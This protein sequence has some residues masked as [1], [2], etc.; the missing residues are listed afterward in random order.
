[1]NKIDQN[2]R[3][4][5]L[6]S[7]FLIILSSSFCVGL[8]FVSQNRENKEVK[9]ES[10]NVEANDENNQQN[11]ENE[12]ETNDQTNIQKE[13]S[14]IN[15]TIEDTTENV[16]ET[17]E[18]NGIENNNKDEETTDSENTTEEENTNEESTDSTTEENGEPHVFQFID[19]VNCAEEFE[20]YNNFSTKYYDLDQTGCD[21]VAPEAGVVSFA[22]YV[23]QG[24]WSVKIDY[25]NGYQT[26]FFHLKEYT[27]EKDQQIEKGQKV[28]FMGNT[29]MTP[30]IRLTI[31]FKIDNN[32]S[33]PREHFPF[34]GLT[35]VEGLPHDP[36]YQYR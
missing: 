33:N 22:G 35:E 29:G 10:T 26:Q 34:N 27:V 4:I 9:I 36:Y 7:A 15:Q 19:P 32:F 31:H 8:Y 25:P 24:G 13:N 16:T 3:R 5:T 1:M 23:Y 21:V 12:I 6:I 14:D 18:N 17:D 30:D 28:G 20:I 11:D 2:K